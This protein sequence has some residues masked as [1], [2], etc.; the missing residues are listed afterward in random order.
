MNAYYFWPSFA[1]VMDKNTLAR[2]TVYQVFAFVC[3]FVGT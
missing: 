2:V 1:I 3:F